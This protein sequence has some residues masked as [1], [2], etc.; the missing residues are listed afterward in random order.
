ML[1]SKEIKCGS[2]VLWHAVSLLFFLYRLTFC[3]DSMFLL[4]SACIPI[5]VMLIRA[6]QGVFIFLTSSLNLYWGGGRALEPRIG[7]SD[8]G[9]SSVWVPNNVKNW[10]NE[11]RRGGS[12]VHEFH[13]IPYKQTAKLQIETPFVPK[14]LKKYNRYFHKIKNFFGKEGGENKW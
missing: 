11:W 9:A 14:D 2:T 8:K 13:F 12:K 5:M 10:E 7:A 6:V 4:K 3:T 1:R